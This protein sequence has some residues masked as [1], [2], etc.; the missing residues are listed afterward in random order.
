MRQ[1]LAFL[2]F[3]FV[4]YC[5]ECNSVNSNFSWN[6]YLLSLLCVIYCVRHL[7]Q[8]LISSP[9]QHQEKRKRLRDIE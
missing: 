3:C 9:L 2:C 8:N 4:F 6:K 1:E 7:H 5:R